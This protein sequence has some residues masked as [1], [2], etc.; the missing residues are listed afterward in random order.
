MEG[1]RKRESGVAKSLVL[2]LTWVISLVMYFFLSLWV[3]RWGDFLGLVVE[4]GL[5]EIGEGFIAH[6]IF[7][8]GGDTV[9]DGLEDEGF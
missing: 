4:S 8:E 2:A 1:V 9:E 7:F 5:Q 3:K 6:G